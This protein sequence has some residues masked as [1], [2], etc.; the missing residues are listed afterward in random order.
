[1][2]ADFSRTTIANPADREVRRYS[3]AYAG[4]DGRDPL[5]N[6]LIMRRAYLPGLGIGIYASTSNGQLVEHG[7][8][9]TG[10]RRGLRRLHRRH[11]E[12]LTR[13]RYRRR[14]AGFDSSDS[15]FSDD[16]DPRLPSSRTASQAWQ[17]SSSSSPVFALRQITPLVSTAC[18]RWKDGR[19]LPR[20][21]RTRAAAAGCR[22]QAGRQQLSGRA[23]PN[24][25]LPGRRRPAQYAA[26][27]QYRQAHS[28]RIRSSRS[29]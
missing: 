16:S 2:G 28:W 21:R 24:A 27:A 10:S 12:D 8:I 13:S 15:V 4:S 29:C 11:S 1:M 18:A 3:T 14:T 26:A 19:V 17:Q 23:P 6:A 5:A 7:I 20:R 22:G 25:Q 9:R